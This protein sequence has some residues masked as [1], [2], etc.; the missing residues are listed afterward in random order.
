[1]RFQDIPDHL[2]DDIFDIVEKKESENKQEFYRKNNLK[3]G[4]VP[5]PKNDNLYHRI[6]F[7]MKYV[8][9]ELI[10][11]I[12][13]KSQRELLKK[14]KRTKKNRYKKKP[15]KIPYI[16]SRKLPLGCDPWRRRNNI[17]K[18][19]YLIDKYINL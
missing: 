2:L 11:T 5:D 8:F 13:I 9:D 3:R 15:H 4:A 10:K 16:V 7:E 6:V 1:M 18:L 14:L 12:Y 19:E 17:N